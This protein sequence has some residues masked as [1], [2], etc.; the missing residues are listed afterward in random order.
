MVNKDILDI[1][2]S[3]VFKKNSLFS[4]DKDETQKESSLVDSF[5]DNLGIIY[6]I[7]IEKWNPFKVEYPPYLLLAG[8]RGILAYLKFIVIDYNVKFSS[9]L[10]SVDLSSILNLIKKVD[11][12][13]DRPTFI[14]YIVRFSNFK[15][16]L[17]ET[18]EMIKDRILSDNRSINNE[19]TRYLTDIET[20]G[21]LDNLIQLFIDL[22]KSKVKMY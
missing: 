6:K 9:E 16:I 5:I 1:F 12:D 20:T 21:T 8:D 13:L 18:I 22:K 14:I 2:D 3:Q 15:G 10:I 19:K 11:S 17:F 7:K 4:I